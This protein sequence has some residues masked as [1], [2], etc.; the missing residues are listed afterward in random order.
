MLLYNMEVYQ[1]K[2]VFD[3]RRI[4][5][6]S[7]L[8]ISGDD[9]PAK[10]WV[11]RL[12]TDEYVKM[13]ALPL[14]MSTLSLVWRRWTWI[15]LVGLAWQHS[16]IMS[17]LHFCLRYWALFSLWASVP[18]AKVEIRIK[19]TG[20]K[21]LPVDCVCRFSKASSC[22]YVHPTRQI[23]M[24][25]RVQIPSENISRMDKQK[26]WQVTMLKHLLLRNCVL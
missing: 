8:E 21:S 24:S 19:R 5:F 20:V 15:R 23:T 13:L 2:F 6:R 7:F 26:H 25:Y 1:K 12:N 18:G 16:H 4:N 3:F 22:T 10:Y 9:T 14:M 11:P 17:V